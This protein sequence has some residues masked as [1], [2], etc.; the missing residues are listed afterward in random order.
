MIIVEQKPKKVLLFTDQAIVL[1]RDAIAYAAP[2]ASLLS[3]LALSMLISQRERK[4]GRQS[5][6]EPP[7]GRRLRSP[8]A[9]TK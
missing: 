3:D 1:D 2:S 6:I 9:A 4:R 7:G 5:V 8:P